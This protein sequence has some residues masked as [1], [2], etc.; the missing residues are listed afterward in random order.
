MLKLNHLS[1]HTARLGASLG[2]IGAVFLIGVAIAHARQENRGQRTPPIAVPM[3]TECDPFTSGGPGCQKGSHLQLMRSWLITHVSNAPINMTQ[4]FFSMTSSVPSPEPTQILSEFQTWTNFKC[5][6]PVI[7][8]GNPSQAT[9]VKVIYELRDDSL[10]ATMPDGCYNPR[11]QNPKGVPGPLTT[12]LQPGDKNTHVFEFFP[13]NSSN[14]LNAKLDG[15]QLPASAS[16][17]W[18]FTYSRLNRPYW[19]TQRTQ[20]LAGERVIAEGCPV[21]TWYQWCLGSDN[22]R[23]RPIFDVGGNAGLEKRLDMTDA[24]KPVEIAVPPSEKGGASLG[25]PEPKQCCAP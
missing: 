9:S 25:E 11:T 6:V 3:L 5:T 4:T 1:P 24:K 23:R 10:S 18:G 22:D 16:F 15:V 21:N 13:S 20:V 12:W 8:G 7:P 2:T 14:Q 17:P 19:I